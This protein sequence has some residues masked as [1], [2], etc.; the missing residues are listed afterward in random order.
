[1]SFKTHIPT[2]K[3][4]K[5]TRQREG[6][7]KVPKDNIKKHFVKF[8][9]IMSLFKRIDIPLKLFTENLEPTELLEKWS[10]IKPKVLSN[11]KRLDFKENK[12][13]FDSLYDYLSEEDKP[14]RSD[15]IFVFGSNEIERADKAIELY[16][17]GL[18]PK[19]LF[20]GGMHSTKTRTKKTEAKRFK[21]HA[22]NKGVREKD[23]ITEQKSITIVDNIRISLNLMDKSRLRPKKILLVVSPIV[24]RRPY[25]SFCKYTKRIEFYRVGSKIGREFS[26]QNWHKSDE[27][28]LAILSE[29][30][31]MRAAY[32]FNDI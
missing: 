13:L 11:F 29:Y 14:K 28:I 9:L 27:G 3:N 15:L 23:I 8:D 7:R 20:S 12:K 17:E 2:T 16:K 5:R 19:I 30:L 21:E 1:M 31:K 32:L 18:A 24:L 10:K 6:K 26:K 25:G 4:L 22:L